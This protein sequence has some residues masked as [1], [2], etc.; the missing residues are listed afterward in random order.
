[1]KSALVTAV[2]LV[3]VSL[4]AQAHHGGRI[5]ADDPCLAN[6][7]APIPTPPAVRVVQLVNCSGEALLGAANAAAR[8]GQPITP[9]F[10]RE[11]TWVMQPFPSPTGANVLT[12]DIPPEWADT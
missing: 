5:A 10:P 12:I 1:M 7:P 8:A 2:L 4:P 6:L 3:L 11:N 9:V